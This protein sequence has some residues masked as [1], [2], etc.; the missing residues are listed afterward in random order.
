MEGDLSLPTPS[1]GHET[2]PGPSGQDGTSPPAV[3]ARMQQLP[4]AEQ[5]A[6]AGAAPR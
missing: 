3:R 4:P 2:R 5:S 1:S 6:G